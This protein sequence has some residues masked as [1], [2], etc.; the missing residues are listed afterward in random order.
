MIGTEM[1]KIAKK[2][3]VRT[4]STVLADRETHFLVY[5]DEKKGTEVIVLE[6]SVEVKR[7]N[8]DRTVVVNEGYRVAAAKDGKLSEP[9][10]IDISNLDRGSEK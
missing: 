9:E 6:G 7:K 2:F 3:E 10:K 5:E 1:G 8:E 4:K